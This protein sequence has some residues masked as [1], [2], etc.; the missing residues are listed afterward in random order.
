MTKKVTPRPK[1][2]QVRVV[3]TS[4]KMIAKEA[5]RLYSKYSEA[6]LKHGLKQPSSRVAIDW[7]IY[8]LSRA[9]VGEWPELTE[10]NNLFMLITADIKEE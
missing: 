3:T 4:A 10:K 9:G 1:N 5:R 7:M 2:T 6:H 8:E